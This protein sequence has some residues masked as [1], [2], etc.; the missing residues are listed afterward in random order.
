MAAPRRK[1]S[2]ARQAKRRAQWK[3]I[4]AQL[5]DCSNCGARIRP[6]TDLHELRPLPRSPGPR[7]PRLSPRPQ[8]P[9]A[10]PGSWL[11]SP[12]KARPQTR[13]F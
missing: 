9:L 8:Y 3:G 7:R 6:H 1:H 10:G 5:V 2:R 4:A 11:L 13:R 12:R